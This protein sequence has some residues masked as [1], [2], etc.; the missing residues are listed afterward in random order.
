MGYWYT[1][2]LNLE[3]TERKLKS[4]MPRPRLSAQIFSSAGTMGL[5]SVPGARKPCKQTYN[6]ILLI[7]CL[8]CTLGDYGSGTTECHSQ[9]LKLPNT[10]KPLLHDK[11]SHNPHNHAHATFLAKL[12]QIPIRRSKRLLRVPQLSALTCALSLSD[13][14]CIALNLTTLRPEAEWTGFGAGSSQ[15]HDTAPKDGVDR[16]WSRAAGAHQLD[17]VLGHFLVVLVDSVHHGIDER[18]LV[19]LRH[20]SH[21]AKVYVRDAAVRQRKDVARVWVPMEQ[22]KLH[23]HNP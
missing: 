21:I 6:G 22:P 7:L 12:G 11:R 13:P 5:M 3:V 16:F 17:E 18:L 4:E 9:S 20:L 14:S 8:V 23:T 1:S 15:P 10:R 2:S 19:L